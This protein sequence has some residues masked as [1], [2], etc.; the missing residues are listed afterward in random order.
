ML[1]VQIMI[2]RM[3]EKRKRSFM[4]LN[5]LRPCAP[6]GARIN[7]QILVQFF[8][9]L[10]VYVRQKVHLKK[11]AYIIDFLSQQLTRS[12]GKKSR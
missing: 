2:R 8:D 12:R 7:Y 4:I 9:A 1:E 10:I 11:N 6:K 3:N 5:P